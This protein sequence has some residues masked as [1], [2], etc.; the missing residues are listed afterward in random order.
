VAEAFAAHPEAGAVVGE[1]EQ[2]QF[3]VRGKAF[4]FNWEGNYH[5]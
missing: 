2:R 4:I 3:V 1:R 5:E